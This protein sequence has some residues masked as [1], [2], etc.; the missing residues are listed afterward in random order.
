MNHSGLF[1]ANIP[2]ILRSGVPSTWD[3]TIGHN[4]CFTKA[5]EIASTW[6]SISSQESHEYPLYKSF[7][8]WEYSTFR[9]PKN[10]FVVFLQTD[11][12]KH[13][14][15]VSQPWKSTVSKNEGSYRFLTHIRSLVL[16]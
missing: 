13:F 6:K 16:P 14:K 11:R 4:L 10:G 12:L 5:L 9:V 2:I 7:P 8:Y 15:I 1:S 3:L